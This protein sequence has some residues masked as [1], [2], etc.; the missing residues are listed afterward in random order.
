MSLFT[1]LVR[2]SI[3]HTKDFGFKEISITWF[4]WSRSGFGM[5]E[6]GDGAE[7]GSDECEEP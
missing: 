4:W 1:T 7:D 2:S 3:L 6:E 5:V